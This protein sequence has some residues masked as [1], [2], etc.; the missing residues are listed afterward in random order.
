MQ[1]NSKG[2]QFLQLQTGLQSNSKS[3]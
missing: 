1:I 2:V 3:Y